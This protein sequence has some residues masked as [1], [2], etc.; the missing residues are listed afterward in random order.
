MGL[1]PSPPE[2]APFE[3][4]FYIETAMKILVLGSSNSIR[5]NAWTAGITESIPTVTF[6]NL[7][8]GGSPGVQFTSYIN[9][10][11]SE[12]DFVIFDSLPNDEE[13]LLKRDQ[14]SELKY[15]NNILLELF[16]T[17]SSQSKLIILNIPTRKQLL[18]SDTQKEEKSKIAI[19]REFLANI[20]GAQIIDVGSILKHFSAFLKGNYQNLYENEA[21]PFPYILKLIGVQIGTLI[22][23][24][25]SKKH[26]AR[27]TH[28]FKEY[29]FF[30][31]LCELIDTDEVKLKNTLMDETFYLA[32]D[33]KIDLSKYADCQ[34]IGFYANFSDSRAYL[35]ITTDT[36]QLAIKLTDISTQT[37]IM[38]AFVPIPNGFNIVEIFCSNEPAG[39]V[40]RPLMVGLKDIPIET[41]RLVMRD[42]IFRKNLPFKKDFCA[43]PSFDEKT[44]SEE[45]STNLVKHLFEHPTFTKQNFGNLI[46]SINNTSLFYD[47]HKNSCYFIDPRLASI[48]PVDLTP[49]KLDFNEKGDAYF[50]IVWNSM[51]I[52]LTAYSSSIVVEHDILLGCTPR[53]TPNLGEKLGQLYSFEKHEKQ[54]SLNIN[55]KYLRVALDIAGENIR[56]DRLRAG[57]WEKFT[58][59]Q[60][61]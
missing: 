9:I 16:A 49:V 6:T 34:C 45:V 35:N 18:F 15:I 40:Y 61:D 11:F 59:G 23:S 10:D 51:K 48:L 4:I 29:Y 42:F 41:P 25:E 22:S 39:K 26:F 46:S 33:H 47:Q 38:K 3:E 19:T 43:N 56:H 52:M 30:V 5:S 8:A 28:S 57:P 14:Y 50:Y 21:H 20:V 54:F 53:K 27:S 12:Y 55:G 60:I 58:Y 2:P 36:D 32:K 7:S 37:K 1:P 13:Y 24:S 31:P 17:I 44:I